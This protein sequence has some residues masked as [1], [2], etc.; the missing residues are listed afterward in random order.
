[1]TVPGGTSD[2]FNLTFSSE[3]LTP[4][5]GVLQ[6]RVVAVVD[7]VGSVVEPHEARTLCSGGSISTHTGTW[8][9]RGGPGDYRF[10]AQLRSNGVASTI[11]DWMFQ[12][13]VYD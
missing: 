13:V 9:L 3:C 12:V 10:S 8:V 1:M 2:L 5:S 6:I 7:G 4:S 11:D